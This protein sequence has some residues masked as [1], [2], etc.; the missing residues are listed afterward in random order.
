[1]TRWGKKSAEGINSSKTFIHYS[2]LTNNLKVK[3]F[4]KGTQL[5]YLLYIFIICFLKFL[6]LILILFKGVFITIVVIA[7]ITFIDWISGVWRD[8]GLLLVGNWANSPCECEYLLKT[9]CHRSSYSP[10]SLLQSGDLC[11]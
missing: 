1:M 6:F 10:N 11:T 7:S 4:L 8:P 9:K 2:T 3:L 5:L